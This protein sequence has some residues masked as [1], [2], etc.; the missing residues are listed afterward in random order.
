MPVTSGLG[1]EEDHRTVVGQWPNG[2]HERIHQIT[3]EVTPPQDHGI[4]DLIGALVEQLLV[5]KGL[6]GSPQGFVTVVV[7]SDLLDQVIALEAEPACD[8]ALW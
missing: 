1:S 5:E 4:N 3:V 6:E 8:T 7:E 2:I